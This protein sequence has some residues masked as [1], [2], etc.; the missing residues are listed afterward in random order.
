M[1]DV[2]RAPELAPPSGYSHGVRARGALLAVA[3]QVA[4]DAEGRIV[5]QDFVTQFSAALQNVVAV[6]RAA[7][8]DAADLIA[9]TIFVT[10]KSAY[11]ACLRP[12]GLA[13]RAVMGR[14]YPAMT[15]VEVKGLIEPGALV[16]IQGLAVLPERAR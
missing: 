14:H 4:W 2:I 15:L 1:A 5:G 6:V 11:L 16:E 12:L 8:G 13:Y 7:G 9:L 10:N 3:G